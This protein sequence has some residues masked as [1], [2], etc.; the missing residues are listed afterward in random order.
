[1][2]KKAKTKSCLGCS[3]KFLTYRNYDYCQNCAINNNRYAQNHCPEC[4]D[5][6]GKVKFKNQK[7]RP[8]KTCY[9]TPSSMNKPFKNK[10]PETQF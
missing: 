5:G 10:A 7:A 2:P 3:D 8:C 9:L 6:S 4:G 1:M